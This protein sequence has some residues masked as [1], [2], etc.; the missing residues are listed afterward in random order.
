M[1]YWLDLFTGTT[2]DEF[3]KAGATVTGFRH[4]M[5]NQV[6]K[7]QPGDILLC[8]MTGVMRWIGAL[9]VQ[10]PSDDKRD[11]WKD[12]DFPIRLRV[13]PIVM[14]EAENGIPMEQL[15]GK[16]DFYRG[17][18]DQGKFHGFVRFSPN[19]FRRQKDGE[20][21]LDS[22]ARC[23][24][25]TR[26]LE[27][28]YEVD[29]TLFKEKDEK[30]L[31]EAVTKAGSVEQV[32]GDMVGFLKIFEPLVPQI[33]NFFDNVLVMDEDPKIRENRLG[34]LQAISNLA[35]GVVDMTRLE[36]F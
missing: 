6:S 28:K 33:T 20:L 15:E 17:P 14:L 34:L 8:Y 1:N 7:V 23:V 9:E 18:E 16:T 3:R 2:W 4:R 12:A 32:P 35:E 31:G 19:L 29:P 13:R 25:I 26:D 24:R 27:E 21:I 10:G 30:K 5:R 11:I 22:F 36:G